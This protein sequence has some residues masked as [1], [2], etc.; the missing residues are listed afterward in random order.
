METAIRRKRKRVIYGSAAGTAAVIGLVF[1]AIFL[2]GEKSQPTSPT[3]PAVSAGGQPASN[4]KPASAPAQSSTPP[5]QS[6]APNG[7]SED[8]SSPAAAQENQEP[9]AIDVVQPKRSDHFVISVDRIASVQPYYRAD[10]RS[11]VAGDVGYIQKNINDHVKKGETLVRIDVPDL[12]AE[13]NA[14]QA[15]I[16][17]RKREVELAQKQYDIAL[18]AESVAKAVIGQ[19]EAEHRSAQATEEYRHLEY[20]RFK[21][22]VS[23]EHPAAAPAMADEAKRDWAAAQ[24]AS[25]GADQAVKKAQADYAQAQVNAEAANTQIDLQKA[26]FDVAERDKDLADANLSYATITSPFNG[27][28]VE[29]NIDPG[30]FVQ[31]SATAQTLPLISI[32]RVDLVTISMEVPDG[33]A[34]YVS[35]GAEAE[36]RVGNLF[37]RGKV[38]RYSPSIES[39]DRTMHVEVD[40]FNGTSKADYARF[41]QQHKATWAEERKG[42]DDPFPVEPEFTGAVVGGGRY[43]LLPGMV[44][45]MRLFLQK[46]DNVFLIPSRAV[47]GRAG[48]TFVAQ[49]VDGKVKLTEVQV[50]ADDTMLS[51]VLVVS[52]RSTPDGDEPVFS[53]L[54]GKERIALDGKELKDG[55]TV[56]PSLKGW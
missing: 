13:V 22:L 6:A 35:Q 23:G 31:N 18:S 39:Q 43:P 10:L 37:A 54:T 5:N 30:S 41:V 53:E 4:L 51:K 36:F 20:N 47:F 9:Q 17:Q 24:A 8:G 16:E 27:V 14:K 3:Q 7:P 12:V 2:S 48:R 50:Q 45:E 15:V 55:E 46:F 33:F 38:T 32:A 44:G 21:D 40:L 56:T 29:R 11:R 49:V 52:Y 26:L 28:V 25:Q 42:A 19:R 1:A 34:P